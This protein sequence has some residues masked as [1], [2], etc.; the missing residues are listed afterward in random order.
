M[1]MLLACWG[2]RERASAADAAD[3]GL[4]GDR[5][6]ASAFDA[7]DAGLFGDHGRGLVQLMLLMLACLGI[8]AKG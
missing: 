1:L 7:A 3:A 5:G 8:T 4:F 6:R 2:S